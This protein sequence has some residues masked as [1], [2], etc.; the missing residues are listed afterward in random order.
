M[1]GPPFLLQIVDA[2]GVVVK[3]PA[4]GAL[5]ADL[6]AT[7]VDTILAHGA[8]TPEASCQAA[9][10]SGLAAAVDHCVDTI[11]AR[12]V[13]F[14]RTEAHVAAD[15]RAGLHEAL[16]EELLVQ[17][18]LK[19]PLEQSFATPEMRTILRE[20]LRVALQRLK[21]QTRSVV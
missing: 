8:T 4:G 11:V 18:R 1:P 20:G 21:D 17:L 5:E 10:K 19:L 16:R 3:L 14:W 2:E 15:I 12:G 7:C 9:L 6:L 13:G